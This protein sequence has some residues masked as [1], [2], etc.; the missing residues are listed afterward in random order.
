MTTLLGQ[1]VGDLQKARSHPA[2]RS[3]LG[4][5]N[6]SAL[7]KLDLALG[8]SSLKGSTGTAYGLPDTTSPTHHSS[9]LLGSHIAAPTS[10]TGSPCGHSYCH[11]SQGSGVSWP[12]LLGGGESLPAQG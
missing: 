3:W 2:I 10:G 8:T 12:Q 6:S 9:G 11:G 5:L 4:S 7:Y 1:N